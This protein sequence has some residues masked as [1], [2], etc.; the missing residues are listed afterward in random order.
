MR[1]RNALIAITA[2]SSYLDTALA[3]PIPTRSSKLFPTKPQKSPKTKYQHPTAHFVKKAYKRP[4][5]FEKTF[6]NGENV[7]GDMIKPPNEVDEIPKTQHNLEKFGV[8]DSNDHFP[9][10]GVIP[11][12]MAAPAKQLNWDLKRTWKHVI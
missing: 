3:R 9:L 2:L 7:I 4:K 10:E 11:L 5:A 6:A 8:K 1:L 12:E